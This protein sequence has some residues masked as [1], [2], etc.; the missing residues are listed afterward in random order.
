MPADERLPILAHWGFTGGRFHQA[1]GDEL[2]EIDLDFLQ[3]FTFFDP[4][5]PERAE[6]VLNA[7]CRQFGACDGPASVPAPTGTAHAYDLVHLLAHA[8]EAAGSVNR[9]DVRQSLETLERHEGLVRLYQPP[10]TPEDHD[11][12]GP[13]DLRLATYD[14]NGV[15]RPLGF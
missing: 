7:Y 2:D 15:I 1:V 14:E 4:P 13:E 3:T 10:F 6:R 11:A 12:L 9:D 5:F 8:I